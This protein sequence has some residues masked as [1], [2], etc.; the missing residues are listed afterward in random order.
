MGNNATSMPPKHSPTS[1]N[2]GHT[3]T[4]SLSSPS[5][6]GWYPVSPV[7]YTFLCVRRSSTTHAA[8]IACYRSNPV[9]PETCCEGVQNSRNFAFTA[10]PPALEGRETRK[11]RSS[12]QSSS[13][14]R[15]GG[16]FNVLE[17]YPA[18]FSPTNM[19]AE[20]KG[21]ARRPRR[22][23]ISVLVKGSDYPGGG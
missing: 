15:E 8:Q 4:L 2:A 12:Q 1:A 21:L 6:T 20:D 13:W 22:V 19:W 14:T 16:V 10:G 3:G 9:Q 5:R 7:K 18:S 17:R 11:R 23:G